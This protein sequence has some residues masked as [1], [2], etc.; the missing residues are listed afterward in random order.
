MKS[1]TATNPSRQETPT[2]SRESQSREPESNVRPIDKA[3]DSKLK[4]PTSSSPKPQQT[5]NQAPDEEQVRRR[6]YELYAEGG[7]IDGND[8]E[9]WFAAERELTGKGK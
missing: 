5:V 4:T 7:Y 6:A 3:S 1:A 2:A 8:E 9:H